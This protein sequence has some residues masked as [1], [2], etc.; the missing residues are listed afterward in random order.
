MKIA[1]VSTGLG[2]VL[3]GFELFTESLFHAMRRYAPH[4]EVTLF[5]GGGRPG[6]RRVVVPTF[7]DKTSLRRDE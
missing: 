5:Q 6:E 7:I 1:L 3:Q 2:R 4:T